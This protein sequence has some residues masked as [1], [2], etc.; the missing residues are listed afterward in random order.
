MEGFSLLAKQVLGWLTY[1]ERL[2]SVTEIQYAI[3]V[4]SREQEFDEDNLND[5]NELVSVCAG[6]VVVDDQSNVIRLVHYTTQ[7]YFVQNGASLFPGARQA[8]ADSCLTYLLYNEFKTGWLYEDDEGDDDGE[9][10][11][12]T[13]GIFSQSNLMH[14]WAPESLIAMLRHHPFYEYAAQYWATHVRY[15]VEDGVD[16][17][18]LDFARDDHKISCAAQV[19]LWLRNDKMVYYFDWDEFKSSRP[20]SAMHLLSYL[21]NDDL[22][23]VLLDHSFEADV[24]DSN[25][26]TPLWWAAYA[27]QKKVVELL[28]S[29][30]SVDVNNLNLRSN[31][32]AL[33]EA[34]AKGHV[35][36]VKLLIARED[37]DLRLCNGKGIT[38][39]AKAAKEVHSA[40]VEV[41]LTRK[42][43]VADAKCWK[44]KTPLLYAAEF[45]KR[46]GDIVRQLCKRSDV[47]I[48]AT[49]ENGMTV[50]G[51]VAQSSNAG[52]MKMLLAC[53]DMNN[54]DQK[55]KNG[56]TPL[57]YAARQ[58]RPEVVELLLSRDDVDVNAKDLGDQTPLIYATMFGRRGVTELLLS[59]DGVDVNAKTLFGQTPLMWAARLGHQAVTEVLLS[60]SG[61][62][63][64]AKS[65]VGHTPLMFAAKRGHQAIVELLL[66]H[67]G[68]DANAKDSAG[69]TVLYVAAAQGHTDIVK[70]LLAR[71]EID[72]GIEDDKGRNTLAQLEEDTA[73]IAAEDE[74]VPQ[75]MGQREQMQKGRQAALTLLRAALKER[76]QRE[77]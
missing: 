75:E 54:A 46:R 70:L 62:D 36:I 55:N 14:S 56:I 68:I 4:E 28:L 37:V 6:L 31:H 8:I 23:S 26:A 66:S 42:D 3:A 76:A 5:V 64:N 49:E 58:G 16:R 25:N 51:W 53:T 61:V 19:L 48:N 22:I 18:F 59:R 45:D 50:L 43:I 60:H 41:L 27:G 21:G 47:D 77:S 72:L 30:Q 65:L 71:S 44:G 15:G 69:S 24:K 73:R 10:T 40:V 11:N 38:P 52:L 33:F 63:A 20:V 32:T 35:E 29:R 12:D 74:S 9:N 13:A 57:M 1:A 7:E 2:L 39:L 67:K 17:L 34:V